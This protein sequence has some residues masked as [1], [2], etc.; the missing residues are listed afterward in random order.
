MGSSRNRY[1]AGGDGVAESALPAALAMPV[2]V[3]ALARAGTGPS[4]PRWS[5]DAG[6][7]LRAAVLADLRRATYLYGVTCVLTV[8]GIV[9][10]VLAKFTV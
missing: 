5:G 8:G 1:R 4:A 6:A 7:V 3:H 10:L 9:L 2:P